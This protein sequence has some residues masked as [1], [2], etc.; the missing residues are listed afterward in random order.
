MGSDN[1]ERALLALC[2]RRPE[3]VDDALSH[4]LKASY[5]GS[6]KHRLLWKG[7]AEDRARGIGPDEATLY[8]RHESYVGEGRIFDSWKSFNDFIKEL[9]VSPSSKHSLSGYVEKIAESAR[10]RQIVGAAQSLIAME[11]DSYSM[12]SILEEASKITSASNWA[13]EGASDPLLAYDIVE[14]YFDELEAQRRGERATTLVLTGVKALDDILIVRPGQMVVVGGRPKQGKTH[15]TISIL[16]NIAKIYSK[17]ALMISAEM[18]RVQLGERMATSGAKM[19]ITVGEAQSARELVLE[20]WQGVP[21]YFDDKPKSINS[22]ITAIR[23][24]KRKLG[25]CVAAVDYLQL[26]KMGNDSN[27]E[28]QVAEA[29]SSLKRLA[30]EL[31]IPI[32]VVAQLNRKADYRDNKRPVLSDLR[33]SGQIEQDADAVAFVY[34]PASYDDEYEPKSDV[35]VIVRAQRNGPTGTARCHWEPGEGWFQDVRD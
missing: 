17:P 34:R 25:I 16:K 7:F 20:Q 26:L 31:D 21:L 2:L 11:Q 9:K 30:M 18:G 29:S 22:A 1:S 8:D 24:A 32:F 6:G 35:E 28:R 4:G 19:G 12:E 14:D 5:F 33:D 27:R 10:R 15:L 13:P 23:T 3:A